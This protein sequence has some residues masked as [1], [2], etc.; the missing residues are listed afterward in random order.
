MLCS[1]YQSIW[2]VINYFQLFHFLNCWRFV[3]MLKGLKSFLILLVPYLNKICLPLGVESVALI[4]SITFYHSFP[5]GAPQGTDWPI[6]NLYYLKNWNWQSLLKLFLFFSHSGDRLSDYSLFSAD[7][8]WCWDLVL[9][10]AHPSIT[11]FMGIQSLRW[12]A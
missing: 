12:L 9:A 3:E 6:L 5:F 2:S 1:F 4:L 8:S 7:S 11:Q 10:W